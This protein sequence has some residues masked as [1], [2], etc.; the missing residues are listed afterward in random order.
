MPEQATA[1]ML[2]AAAAVTTSADLARL[3]RRLRRREARARGGPELTYRELAAL[4]GWSTAII[5][6]YLTGSAL[7]PTDRFDT[8]TRLLGA[9]PRE[10]GALATARDRV[11]D[12]RRAGTGAPTAERA[13]VPR[14]LP[15]APSVFAG[16]ESPLAA[17]DAMLAAGDA[18]IAITGT[19]GVGK[20]AFA[21]R[22]AHGVAERF[23]DG[24]L[25]VNLRGYD[26]NEPLTPAAALARFLRS[27][28]V[29]SA[30]VP[31][32]EDERA[33]RYRSLLAGRRM[34]IVL[35]NAY[36]AEQVRPLLP[37][38]PSCLAVVTS[39][40]DLAGLVARDG[41]RR[42]ELDVL[43][44][45]EAADLLRE[46]VGDRVTDDAA[47]AAEL[48][49]LCWRL[50]LALRVAAE[51]AA[52]RPGAPL[53]ELVADLGE[54]RRRLDFLDAGDPSTSVR[55]VLSWSHRHLAPA[56]ARAFALLGLLPGRDFDAYAM[57]ALA[58]AP[59]QEAE[60]LLRSLGRAQL[61]QRSDGRRH[62]MH[63]M[64]RAYATEL[65]GSALDPRE[66]A[67]A[68]GRLFDYYR[69]AAS[70][71]M[72]ALYI[73]RWGRPEVPAAATPIPD[74]GDPA[75]AR[76]WLDAERDNLV[77]VS[78]HAAPRYST[79]LSQTLWQYLES[80]AGPCT[81]A[82]AIHG[83]AVAVTT[84]DDPGH[85]GA[86]TALGITHWRRGEPEEAYRRLEQ[87]LD[88]HHHLPG[89]TTD[90]WILSTHAGLGLVADQLGRFSDAL[91]HFR[92]GLAFARS[93]GDRDGE[94]GHLI[95]MGHGLLRLERYAEAER[96]FQEGVRL[97]Q[98][99]A[100][101]RVI[102]EAVFGLGEA[103]AGLG[104]HDAAL[105]HFGQALASSRELVEGRAEA[106]ALDAIGLV[107]RRL[108]KHQEA[109]DRLEEALAVAREFG[110]RRVQAQVLNSLGETLCEGGDL[111]LSVSQHEA[112]L[113]LAVETADRLQQ[114]RAYE[115]L[116]D[117]DPP[118]AA[119][120]WRQAEAVYAALE[121][122]AVARV[123]AKLDM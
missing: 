47:A 42:V 21:L 90:R 52:A 58:D 3:L 81:D 120:W 15:A 95:N 43:A 39:R 1:P 53:A 29:E 60:R 102:A 83:H 71:A 96:H 73:K 108:G 24:Q 56:P 13:P 51:Q 20:T 22:W 64:L 7:P 45:T 33:A 9:A 31:P 65:A 18:V 98:E 26:P 123:Q 69:A 41:A 91:G 100:D 107:Q 86:L 68:R 12:A 35:D 66:A 93:I 59:V 114:A 40:D 48:A 77:A 99:V 74:V 27:L 94:A 85:A 16:R 55:T 110:D 88:A 109:L 44:D 6:G 5:G 54:E 103:L 101:Q 34:L 72:D 10:Q 115:G 122:P 87:A 70:A 106:L 117:A 8:L 30:A 19:G 67:E 50:P 28:G 11:A 111:D 2:D 14:E 116:G 32:D 80:G 118:G 49:R 75:R 121:V 17:L 97:G 78:L 46:L 25:Y 119:R 105:T 113:A 37:G 84:P 61:T 4:T 92:R 36:A 89:P 79:D 63:D 82:L 104:R 62:A 23:P 38:N 57:A 112:A 76:A